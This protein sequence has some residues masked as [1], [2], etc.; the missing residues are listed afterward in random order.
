ML[1]PPSKD[2]RA[3]PAEDLAHASG[4]GR[5]WWWRPA[6][7]LDARV[8]TTCLEA[9]SKTKRVI[10][11]LHGGAYVAGSP[12]T[13]RNLISQ[14]ALDADATVVALDYRL[15]PEHPFPAAF[16]D[17]VAGFETLAALMGP[18]ARIA[19]A[20]DSAG[21]GLALATAAAL[22]ARS[23]GQL[24]VALA[25]F[26]P[27]VDLA[28]TGRSLQRNARR[29]AMLPASR[30]KDTVEAY[31][32][33]ADPRDP[34]AS[35]LYAKWETL[36]PPTLIQVSTSEILSDDAQRISSVLRRAGGDVR[37]EL[38]RRTPHAWHFFAPY[39]REAADAVGSAGRF[40]S[41]RLQAA[42]AS[43]TPN[44]FRAAG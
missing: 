5:D 15:A 12:F 44:D 38:W 27:F 10:Y 34:R 7:T 11:Y 31:L 3:A 39:L 35:P 4:L 40:L 13:H 25:V 17:A 8:D 42:P 9:L 36:P 16:E 23:A 32:Q 1:P 18:D 30:V 21:G 33:G 28:L 29:D 19:I 24:P 22:A 43:S 26:S 41:A 20:G 37:L 14:L 2:L 6:A